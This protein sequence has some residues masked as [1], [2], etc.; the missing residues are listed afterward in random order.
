MLSR[1]VVASGN[2][3]KLAELRRILRDLPL[4]FVPYTEVVSGLVLEETGGSF[5]ENA[6]KKATQVVEALRRRYGEAGAREWVL[7]EDSGLEVEVLGGRPGVYSARYAGDGA[8][9]EDNN[10]KLLAELAGRPLA[11]RKAQFRCVVVLVGPQE[12][13]ICEG[14]CPGYI[15]LEPAGNYGFGYDPLFFVPE[16]GKT[17]AELGP[18]IKDQLSHRGQALRQ[19][20]HILTARRLV[21]EIAS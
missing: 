2:L 5:Q 16:Y 15:A 9:D 17:L 19:L 20:R 12:T 13:F 7:A 18:E 14:R 21:P 3:H 1:I 6:H 10:K 4:E 11:E 8:T